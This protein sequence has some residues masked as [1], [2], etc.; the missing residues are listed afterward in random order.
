MK[1]RGV[2]MATVMF[3]FGYGEGFPDHSVATVKI[4]SDGRVE[5]RTAVADVGQG[6]YTLVCQIVGEILAVSMDQVDLITGDTAV[7]RN[8]GST[9]ATRQTYFTGNAV[10][11][12]AETLKSLIYDLGVRALGRTYPELYLQDGHIIPHGSFDERISYAELAHMAAEKGERLEAESAFFPITTPPDENG[13]G[14]RVYVAY[15]FVTQIVEVEV[16]ID[17]GQVEL[18]RVVTAPDVGQA[19]HPQNV[20]GQIEGGTVMG[21]GMA[22]MEKVHFNEE[23]YLL[24]HDLS[25]YLIPTALDVPRLKTVLI[26]DEEPSGPFGAKG[27]GEPACIATAPAVIN[28]I[29]HACGVRIKELP[30]TPEKILR[31]LKKKNQQVIK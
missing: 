8:S 24:N 20:E 16:D 26:E 19:I 6:A 29:Y 23:G 22:L 5:L 27:I 12:A 31:E 13:Q 28:A 11:N 30:A 21:L 4:K 15:T 25:T 17:T 3:G 9:S 1:K 14:E 18:L 7:M 2:G 10:K